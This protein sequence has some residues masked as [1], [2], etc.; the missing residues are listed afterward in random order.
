MARQRDPDHRWWYAVR[1]ADQH[2]MSFGIPVRNGLGV[3]L[4]ASTFLSSRRAA[5]PAMALDFLQPF[6]DSRI[7]FT[8]ALGTA[9]RVNGSGLIEI[10]NANLPR[11]DYDPVTLAPKGLLVEEARTNLFLN[12]LIDGTSLSTQSVTVT[13]VPHT[14]S[15]YGTGTI[16]LSGAAT[17]TVVGTGVY[18]NRQT[19]TF[20][21]IVGVLICT[22]TGS[23]QY[24]QVEV[25]GVAT[26][27]IPT[28]ASTVTRNADSVSMTGTNFSSWYNQTQGTFVAAASSFQGG[29]FRSVFDAQE[30]AN[31]E[32]I[33]QSLGTQTVFEITDN[34][35]SQAAINAGSVLANV[36]GK[37]A[38]AYELNNFASSLN[39][40]AVVTDTTGT[41][42]TTNR[43]FFGSRLAVGEFLN[44][45]IRSIAYYNTRLSN[46][47]L[48][49]LS[50]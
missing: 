9:T 10:V 48:Q 47:A 7:T 25:G 50:V 4:L 24:A 5:Y 22:V 17:A 15:F 3:G 42:P 39:G 11:F 44:G 14:I 8:R 31:Q 36:V 32:R 33:Y 46:A 49:S 18:P 41:L 35:V 6:L 38:S 30:G 19:L 21:P 29:T 16:T 26:S 37:V 28:A 20:T 12:S 40:A 23:V 34:G 45:H 27:F 2:Q 1:K 13:A 43:I